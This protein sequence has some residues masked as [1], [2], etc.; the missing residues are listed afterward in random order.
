MIHLDI[1]EA[2]FADFLRL[3]RRSRH[4][5]HEQ[6]SKRGAGRSLYRPAV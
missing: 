4:A 3:R 2:L 6:R 5:A 1:A